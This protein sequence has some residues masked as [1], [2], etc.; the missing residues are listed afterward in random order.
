[1]KKKGKNLNTC[2]SEF[3]QP[4]NSGAFAY[5]I[6]TMPLY[7]NEIINTIES[8]ARMAFYAGWNARSK[9]DAVAKRK[10]K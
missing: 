7:E 8:A 9:R 6:R 5:R 4:P 3:W 10:K 1:V 2:F